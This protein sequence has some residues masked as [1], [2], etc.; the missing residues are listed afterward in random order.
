MPCG[1]PTDET[2]PLGRYGSSHVGRAKSV[3]RMGLGH[4]YGRRMQ[5]ISGIH[6][7]WSLPGVSSEEYFAPDPQLPPP[8]LCAAVPVWRLARAVPLLCR[9]ARAQPAAAG[10]Q[11]QALYLPHATS[12]RMGRLGYQSD[13]QATLNVSYNGLEGYANSLHQAL[14]QPYPRLRGNWACATRAATT[15]SW[16]PACCRSK[17][18]ST[19]PS[20]P[21]ARCAGRA[22]RARLA[23]ARRGVR[24]SALDGPRPIRARGH[25]GARPCGCWTCSCCTAC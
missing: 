24:G 13:A 18:S 4:R 3:Y 9:G 2:I 12:L 5:T 6:Y 17:T 22:P 10:R 1:L 7:N 16:A 21:S 8:R 23:R 19:A 25:H 14:T 20:A 15:T 11:G